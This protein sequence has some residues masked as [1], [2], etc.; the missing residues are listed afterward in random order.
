M[1]DT[2]L[3]GKMRRMRDD[4]LKV[5][6]ALHKRG[7]VEHCEQLRGAA[8]ILQTWID[9]ISAEVKERKPAKFM[10]DIDGDALASGGP[11]G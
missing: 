11:D 10:D 6:D 1:H 8:N 2:H 9:G 3:I 4:M 5:S 7:N